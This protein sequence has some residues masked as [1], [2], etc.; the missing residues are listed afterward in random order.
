M[1]WLKAKNKTNSKH[2]MGHN[3]NFAL[4]ICWWQVWYGSSPCPVH[5]RIP[6]VQAT[7]SGNTWSPQKL[8]SF[9]LTA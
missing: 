5:S 6:P 8:T 1:L 9:P 4:I 7:L 2:S 3:Y